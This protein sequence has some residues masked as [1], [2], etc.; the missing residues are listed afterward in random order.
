AEAAG[1]AE[2]RGAHALRVPQV[3][4]IGADAEAAFLALEWIE[5][6]SAG[7]ATEQAL[8]E[9]LATQHRCTAAAYGWDR[10]NAIGA[11]PQSNAWSND[12][13]EFWRARRLEPQIDLAEQN[14]ARTRVLDRARQLVQ[15]LPAYFTSYRPVP[16]LLHGDLWGGNWSADADG[17]P[18]VFDPA[19][20]YGDREADLAM[21]RLFGGFGTGFYAAYQA[22]W[23][24]DAAAGYRRDL[25]NLYHVLNH[26]NLFG[27]GYLEQAARMIERLLAELGS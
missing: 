15:L 10:D 20:Y 12:W 22:A 18:V 1:L 17:Q 9:R 11:T 6:G 8:G 4:A 13:V 21:T 26:Y 25:Y 24:L 14:G 19:V 7:R 2:L 16:S 5:F 3:I 23:P 27:G